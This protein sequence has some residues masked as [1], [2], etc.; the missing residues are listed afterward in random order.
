MIKHVSFDLWDTIF[1]SNK[2]NSNKS[3]SE[4]RQKFLTTFLKDKKQEEISSGLKNTL[5]CA[6]A[7]GEISGIC[8]P[9]KQQY[10]QF[11]WSLYGDQTKKLVSNENYLETLAVNFSKIFCE[12]LPPLINPEFK[13]FLLSLK[14]RNITTNNRIRFN[15]PFNGC[16]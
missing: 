4:S 6:D 10:Y 9:P 16:G 15:K 2:R 7:Y 11:L 5:A 13:K 8:T 3:F 1:V 12:N 14:E